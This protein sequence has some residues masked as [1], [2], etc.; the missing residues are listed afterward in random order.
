IILYKSLNINASLI[1]YYSGWSCEDKLGNSYMIHLATFYDTYGEEFATKIHML[2]CN[3]AKKHKS[4]TIRTKLYTLVSLLNEFTEHCKT[5]DI[6]EYSFKAENSADFMEN[7]LNSMFFKS[8]MKNNDPKIF[9][10]RWKSAIRIF[11]D[12]FIDTGYIDEPLKPFLA[13]EF[14]EP[15]TSE[16]SIFIGGDLSEKENERWLVDIPLEI[17]DDEA[18]SLI[19]QRL[20][21]DLEHIRIV[22]NKRFEDINYRLQR[23]IKFRETGKIKPHPSNVTIKNV[24]PMGIDY[25]DN[26]V[27]TFYHYGFGVGAR[28]TTYLGFDAQGDTLLEELCLPTSQSLL[29]LALLLIIEHPK[30]TPSW[31]Q[32]WELFDR[33]GNQVG[34]KQAG[35]HWIA[36]SFKN[37]KGAV[38][39]QQEVVLTDYS[40]SIVDVLIEHT[41]FA[42]ESLQINGGS[43]WRFVM[44]TANLQVASRSK[45]IGKLLTESNR[46]RQ[47]FYVDSYNEDR[48]LILIKSEAKKL[49]PIVTLRSI[50]K[51]RALQTYL[52]TQSINAVAE[53]LGHKEVRSELIEIYLPQ[54]LMNYFN[55]RWVRQFQN[56]II[57]KSLKDSPYLFDA[58]DFNEVSLEVFLKNHNLGE[59]PIYLERASS[60]TCNNKEYINNL[61]ELVF[62]LSTPLFQ[63]LLAIQ[64]IIDNATQEDVFKPVIKKW[65][66]SADFI[67]KH[68]LLSQDSEK[69]RRPPKEA[70]PLYELAL[71]NPLDL[72]LFK[73]SILCR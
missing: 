44:L 21:R 17:K 27:A 5:K 8:L 55:K 65:Y 66:Q 67:L 38:N 31:L 58:L 46:S 24:I 45:N 54:S 14:K 15:K 52:E 32:E 22:C 26:T 37:R 3:Y 13:P 56:A 6:L 42:R 20:D 25:L 16:H 2:I 50:R 28:T 40:K 29:F 4:A 23:N 11:S 47:I 51:A 35:N 53:V 72:V 48:Q 41:R 60:N 57:F 30:I 12:C 43:D 70:I 39:A 18:L 9:I 59:L 68:F 69:Y 19:H 1:K 7:V 61:D 63:V 64:H 34:L 10:K 36:V 73:E 71:N 62:T 49:S 33:N